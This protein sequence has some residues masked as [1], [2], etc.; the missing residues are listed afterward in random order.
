MQFFGSFKTFDAALG[1]SL[2]VCAQQITAV[3]PEEIGCDPRRTFDGRWKGVLLWGKNSLL[4]PRNFLLQMKQLHQFAVFV[5]KQTIGNFGEVPP[6][7][8]NGATV[9]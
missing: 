7:S 3:V 8:G 5:Q 9:Q 6:G 4:S 1:L 2:I